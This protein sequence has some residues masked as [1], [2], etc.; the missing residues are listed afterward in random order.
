PRKAT[1]KIADQVREVA[2]QQCEPSGRKRCSRTSAKLA[3]SRSD[4]WRPC[5]CMQSGFDT[6]T[7]FVAE[8]CSRYVQNDAT[9]AA[10]GKESVAAL[11]IPP[12]ITPSP[13]FVVTLWR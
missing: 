6:R 2:R 3:R 7:G 10:I 5:G 4:N 8:L 9:R 1:I 12:S 13:P 11:E